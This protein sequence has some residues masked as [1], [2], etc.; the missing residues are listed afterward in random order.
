MR[1][2]VIERLV[3]IHRDRA[4]ALRGMPRSHVLAGRSPAWN[5]TH[6]KSSDALPT[7]GDAPRPVGTSVRQDLVRQPR[8][9]DARSRLCRRLPARRPSAVDEGAPASIFRPAVSRRVDARAAPDWRGRFRISAGR[10][11]SL[12]QPVTA[13]EVGK[14]GTTVMPGRP[15]VAGRRCLR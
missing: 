13:A 15:V 6:R 12:A 7:S 3:R 9:I 14:Y 8:A 5:P 4:A 1:L 10:G 11:G 2:Q